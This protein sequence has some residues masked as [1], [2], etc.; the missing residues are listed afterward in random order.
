[1]KKFTTVQIVTAYIITVC[2]VA[3]IAILLSSLILYIVDILFTGLFVVEMM[4]R[5]GTMEA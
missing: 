1:M 4:R 2:V 3:V 5:S